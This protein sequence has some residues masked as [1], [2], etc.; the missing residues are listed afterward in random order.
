[1]VSQ[2]FGILGQKDG[3]FVFQ[4]LVQSTKISKNIDLSVFK[5]VRSSLSLQTSRIRLE[6]LEH[7]ATITVNEKQWFRYIP[8]AY[9]SR[10]KL[11]QLYLNPKR[12]ML[13]PYHEVR[14]GGSRHEKVMTNFTMNTDVMRT[15]LYAVKRQIMRHAI[16]ALIPIPFRVFSKSNDFH[17]MV[18]IGEPVTFTKQDKKN[19]V[20]CRLIF[21]CLL[22]PKTFIMYKTKRILTVYI[23]SLNSTRQSFTKTNISFLDFSE[24]SFTSSPL[25]NALLALFITFN[26]NSMLKNNRKYVNRNIFGRFQFLQRPS[27][28]VFGT[29]RASIDKEFEGFTR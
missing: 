27:A 7:R 24:L 11:I 2:A 17:S 12:S 8:S 13:K 5:I 15:T 4:W 18:S 22:V 3:V 28:H 25:I 29:L 20:K 6:K 16:F 21:L 9:V 23:Y 10:H 1:M 19:M 14:N 26:S